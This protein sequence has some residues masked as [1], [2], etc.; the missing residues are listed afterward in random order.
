MLLCCVVCVFGVDCGELVVEFGDVVGVFFVVCL[1][2]VDVVV[3]D[4]G[5]CWGVE[6]CCF[7]FK[8]G[9]MINVFVEFVQLIQ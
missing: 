8:W 2:Q 7:E 5:E 1:Q 4:I 3:D 6:Y 9:Y